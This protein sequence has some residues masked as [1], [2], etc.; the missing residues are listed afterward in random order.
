[1]PRRP[2]GA[3]SSLAAQRVLDAVGEALSLVWA[4][5]CDHA[6]CVALS[7][8]LDSSVL[9][10][11]VVRAGASPLRA[12]HVNHRLNERAADWARHCEQLCAALGV[13][14]LVRTVDVSRGG[15]QGLEAAARLE[16][17]RA[18]AAALRPGEA[19]LTAH[20]LDDQAET[21][22]IN[23]LRG[24]GVAGLRGIPAR[25]VVLG[26]QVVRPLLEVPRAALR[27]YAQEAG[28]DWVEDPS[29]QDAR[30]ARSY[31]RN[32]IMP[33]LAARWPGA[34]V[35]IARAGRLCGEAAGLID[36]LAEQDARRLVRRGR[37]DLGGLKALGAAR[38]ANVLRFVCRQWLGSVPPEARLR[39]G[40][41]Q[42]LEAGP[43][44]SPLLSWSGGEIRRYRDALYVQQ[45]LGVPC[46]RGDLR[47]SARAGCG[48]DLGEPLGRL[49]LVRAR[50]QGLSAARTGPDLT[51]R[52]RAGGERLRPA[53]TKST[54]ELKK[55]LQERGVVPWMRERIPLLYAGES[56]VAVAGLWVADEFAAVGTEP[57]LRV[58]WDDHPALE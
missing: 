6:F 52:F 35:T 46:P 49:R 26:C 18:L 41:Q 19:V 54:R 31:L 32:E 8:G 55:L 53:G 27:A 16:R 1:M 44:R 23:L 12:I 14:L 56:L 40:L 50:G 51:V 10:H 43:D 34:S 20:H 28:I 2:T 47:I 45:P 58:R 33:K 5:P 25:S 57:G 37:I 29:N 22:L 38:Q 30:I 9:L 4:A 13:P 17:Y 7:G 21:V 42:L 11:A 36:A 15:G 24:A 3:S 39:A 48:L